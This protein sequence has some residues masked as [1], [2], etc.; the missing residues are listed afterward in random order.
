MRRG[1]GRL[2]KIA[3]AIAALVSSLA[4]CSKVTG[5]MGGDDGSCIPPS[6]CRKLSGYA[7]ADTLLE[8]RVL[9]DA[10]A[11][12]P[13]LDALASTGD[14][15]LRNSRITLVLDDLGS[16]HAL[17]PSGGMILDL[18][19]R[20]PG[21]GDE[22]NQVLHVA[23]ILPEDNVVY[24]ELEILDHSP[25]YVAAVLRGRLDGRDADVVT[26][27]ELRP[28]EP[29][30]R[31]RT[32]LFYEGDD[33]QAFFL[34]DGFW[35]GNREVSPFVPLTGGGFVFPPLDILELGDSFQETP[36][37]AAS[38]HADPGG[39]YALVP[40]ARKTLEVFNSTTVSAAGLPRTLLMPG[41]SIAY[42]RLLLA[43]PSRGLS[44]AVDLAFDARSRMTSERHALVRGR[45]VLPGGAPTG[46]HER[47]ASLLFYEPSG[48]GDPDDEDGR[49][50][51]T[52]AVSGTDGSFAV[53]LPANRTFRVRPHRFGRALSISLPFE[54][55]DAG[56]ETV[57]PDLVL[58][59]AAA[60][61]VALTTSGGN[62]LM[63]EIVLVPAE[64]TIARAVGGN[65][66]GQ[67][68]EPAC[69]PY[70]G[71]P[72]GP[73]PACNR[74]LTGTDGRAAF[75]VPPGD[76]FVYATHGPFWTLD[77]EAVTLVAGASSSLALSLERLDGLLP[78]GVLSGD[79]HVHSGLSFD[80]A[81]PE[82]DRARTFV[83]SGV[84]VIAATE[85]D[86]AADFVE[87]IAELGIGDQVKVMPGFETTGQIL[88]Y[89]PPGS[90]LPKVIG[91]Y[92]FWPIVYDRNLSRNGAPDDERLEPGALFDRVGP[93]F[94]GPGV[95]QMNHPLSEAG[96]G[97]DE[98]FLTALGFD[99]REDY[100]AAL[101]RRPDGGLSNL[102]FDA[103]EAMNG[104][105]IRMRLRHRAAWWSLLSQ[106]VLRAGTANSDSHSHGTEVLG[107]PRNLVLGNHD[108]ATFDRVA[109]NDDVRAGRLTGTNGP[110]LL[111]TLPDTG[112]VPRGPSLTPF[113]PAVGAALSIEVRAAPWIPVAEIRIYV[114]GALVHRI[115]GLPAPD[116]A[117]GTTGLVRWQGTVPLAPLLAAIPPA[118]DAW[119]V[120]EAGAPIP[121][122]GDLDH[123]GLPDTTDHDGDGDVDLDDRA[124]LEQSEHFEEPITAKE[125]DP[126]FHL[127]AVAPGTWPTAFT[128]PLLVDRAGDGW[129]A[130]GL[131]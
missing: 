127:N 35:W 79:F 77:R 55:G 121:L 56:E 30:V 99:P 81:F 75:A 119:I 17:A 38:G 125:T 111:A 37:L 44:P 64:P 114:N 33:P 57:L 80:S 96:F 93:L 27:Y 109:F 73:S 70:L 20:E 22:I 12:P 25:E 117:F 110:V 3:I 34:A 103:Q 31:V 82:R 91:H 61:E 9:T 8:I 128:N 6:P 11:R 85:H 69:A 107:Y 115:Q 116:D 129:T 84:H 24:R 97:R 90:S 10:A 104:A 71:P 86:V 105:S 42:E 65:V 131:P 95:I 32:E 94:D 126:R 15:L 113:R 87:A 62:P 112:G 101:D 45:T 66:H 124:N 49:R 36:F 19:S 28:C 123:D 118:T 74:V 4:G 47:L 122:T 72:Y 120:V 67:F 13:G 50:P 14:A 26:R 68:V 48:S 52:E 98:G 63:G 40:C 89:R 54:T 53:L 1:D 106:G 83:A 76:Y 21:A 43:G 2:A 23:G 92:N 100:P 88:F 29:G 5:C 51:W 39:S 60:L 41:D 59:P 130:P 78:P 16:P 102:D 18:A 7:C 58:P 108:L 46:G